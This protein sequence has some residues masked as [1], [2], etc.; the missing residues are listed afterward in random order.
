MEA[1]TVLRARVVQAFRS[2]DLEH[3]PDLTFVGADMPGNEN[4]LVLNAQFHG[5]T[6][7]ENPDQSIGEGARCDSGRGTILLI[8]SGIAAAVRLHYE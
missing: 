8:F 5:L 2:H 7:A 3:V 1:G 6:C 4:T